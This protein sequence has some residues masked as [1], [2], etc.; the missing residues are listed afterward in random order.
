M[1]KDKITDESRSWYKPLLDATVTEMISNGAV[2]GAAIEATPVWMA[3]NQVLIA[4][5]WEATQK[6]QFIWVIAGENVKT[7]YIAGNLAAS[8]QEAA[9]HF[10]LKWQGDSER[11]MKMAN[12]EMPLEDPDAYLEA[13]K[14]LIGQAGFLYDLA[15]SDDIWRRQL[16]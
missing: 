5:V 6:T 14:K 10:S 7:D 9:K 15:E 8:A 4:R 13:C 2:S 3:L 1:E 12:S 11:M 16:K